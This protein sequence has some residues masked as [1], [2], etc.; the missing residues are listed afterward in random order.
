[1]ISKFTLQHNEKVE[2]IK[3][4]PVN[5]LHTNCHNF[6]CCIE[7]SCKFVNIPELLCK[8]HHVGHQDGSKKTQDSRLGVQTDLIIFSIM[9]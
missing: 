4:P 7:F 8:V 5:A 9:K 2:S 6:K 1:M 3:T